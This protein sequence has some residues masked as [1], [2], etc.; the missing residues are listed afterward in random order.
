MII[1]RKTNTGSIILCNSGIFSFQLFV[2]EAFQVLSNHLARLLWLYTRPLSSLLTC[3][4]PVNNFSDI[5]RSKEKLCRHFATKML[6]VLGAFSLTE[7]NP[8]EKRKEK[9]I[10]TYMQRSKG[11]ENNT[12]GKNLNNGNNNKQAFCC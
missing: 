8:K 11:R 10:L 3:G 6:R 1:F 2:R 4:R 5:L 7:G 12:K 9:Y